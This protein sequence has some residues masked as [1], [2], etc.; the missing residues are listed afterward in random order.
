MN[1]YTQT[2]NGETIPDLQQRPHVEETV[3]QK[4]AYTHSVTEGQTTLEVYFQ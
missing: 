1:V 2:L 3:E 4:H